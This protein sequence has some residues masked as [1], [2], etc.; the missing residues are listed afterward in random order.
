MT[1]QAIPNTIE[2]GTEL[3]F[4]MD[5]EYD[6]YFDI[7]NPY[8]PSEVIKQIVE[9]MDAGA[10]WE[11]VVVSYDLNSLVGTWRKTWKHSMGRVSPFMRAEEQ[12]EPPHLRDAWNPTKPGFSSATHW[13]GA[14]SNQPPAIDDCCNWSKDIKRT[15]QNGEGGLN[16]I[17][18]LAGDYSSYC[19]EGWLVF[20]YTSEAAWAYGTITKVWTEGT[21]VGDPARNPETFIRL[22]IDASGYQQIKGNTYISTRHDPIEIEYVKQSDDSW[23]VYPAYALTADILL[24]MRRLLRQIKYIDIDPTIVMK[25]GG[26]ESPSFGSNGTMSEVIS[27]MTAWA[28]PLKLDA[29]NWAIA[30]NYPIEVR[31]NINAVGMKDLPWWTAWRDDGYVYT[32]AIEWTGVAVR[33]DPENDSLVNQLLW[34]SADT[35]MANITY[36]SH[37]IGALNKYHFSQGISGGSTL[38]MVEVSG[39]AVTKKMRVTMTKNEDWHYLLPTNLFPTASDYDQVHIG[40]WAIVD[41][42]A[43]ADEF[44]LVIDWD[45]VPS[46]VWK[47]DT[48][49]IQYPV[50]N[51]PEADYNPPQPNPPVFTTEPYAYFEYDATNEIFELWIKAISC[52]CEDI[53]ESGDVKYRLVGLAE[54]PITVY[55]TDNI[56]TEQIAE[57]SLSEAIGPL[58]YLDGDTSNPSGTIARIPCNHGG[59]IAVDDEVEIFEGT[60]VGVF[61]VVVVSDSTHFDI[62]A[63]YYI[64][65][66]YNGSQTVRKFDGF[67]LA[68]W[69]KTAYA[70]YQFKLQTKDQ[71]TPTNNESIQSDEET[72]IAPTQW[73]L[74]IYKDAKNYD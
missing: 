12:G 33:S 43:V 35:V 29:G 72:L 54:A 14:R 27:E 7:S 60:W 6:W 36:R 62:D 67:V 20:L 40:G 11:E 56:I 46:S 21:E 34:S 66:T 24:E 15:E 61:T 71:A 28:T 68:D 37:V 23:E 44:T 42:M 9:D 5:N 1:V 39:D 50:D 69:I 57:I 4:A 52:Y 65:T 51:L 10:T 16:S 17:V 38:A 25:A 13:H 64:V 31:A 74:E 2:S 48:S 59:V 47:R 18:V 19:K 55:Q 70:N 22:N 63:G 30:G 53:E 41:L 32:Q 45:K 58:F 49:L 26:E 8:T 3:A 73:P